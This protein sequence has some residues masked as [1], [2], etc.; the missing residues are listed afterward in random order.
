MTDDFKT[1]SADVPQSPGPA[2]RRRA[3]RAAAAKG[4]TSLSGKL[5]ARFRRPDVRRRAGIVLL[6]VGGVLVAWNVIGQDAPTDVAS[7][8]T[9]VSDAAKAATAVVLPSGTG[10]VVAAAMPVET[11]TPLAATAQMA[12]LETPPAGTLIVPHETLASAGDDACTVSVGAM[13]LAAA[14]IALDIS[15]PCDA[16]ARV[17]IIQD[18]LAVAVALSDTGTATVEM[19]ALSGAPTVA[20]LVM[21]RDP[22]LIKTEA[23]D[24]DKYHRA[25]LYWQGNAGLELHA[26]EGTS[27]YGTEGHV[28]LENPR[29]IA[30]ALSGNGGYLTSIGDT[31]LA[32]GNVAVIYTVPADLPVE[33]SIEVPVTA[34]NCAAP[35]YGGIIQTGPG[36]AATAQDITLTMPAC[37]AVG[38]YVMLGRLTQPVAVASN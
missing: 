3:Q 26:F 31:D 16:G 6:L 22:V 27:T 24:I 12:A 21:D 9:R 5:I 11:N 13:A 28:G 18:D 10:S 25:V 14:T 35:V 34:E 17:D 33:L 30:H 36:I 29:T 23:V 20:V 15:S 38:D 7:G 32:A 1:T 8:L 2:A 4:S 19:P 37:D